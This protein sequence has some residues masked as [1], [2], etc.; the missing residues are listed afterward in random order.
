MNGAYLDSLGWVYFKLGEY[1]LA[2]E[3]L[4]QAVERDRT[5]PT[6]HDHL[7]ELYAKTNRI[8]LAAAQWSY[9][10]RIRQGACRRRGAGRCGQVQ[11]KLES[12]RIKLAKQ[13]S[14]SAS[15]SR[16]SILRQWGTRRG[17][18]QSDLGES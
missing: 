15:P 17:S 7:G 10:L 4:R 1:E 12:A 8:R 14:A 11:R 18:G 2:E 3:N 16:I 5:D 6:V 9:H 13:E